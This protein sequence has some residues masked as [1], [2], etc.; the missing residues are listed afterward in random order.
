VKKAVKRWGVRILGWVLLVLGI[1]ALPLPGPGAMIILVAMIV[2]ATQY[3]WAEKRLD[4][5]KEW[6]LVGAADSV[7][8]YPRI[9]L[10]ALGVAWLVGLGIFWGIRPDA[11]DW[12]PIHEKWWLVGGWGTGATLIFSGAVA[13]GLLV[14]SLVK[15][16]GVPRDRVVA[17]AT[18]EADA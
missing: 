10:S 8:T 9:V 5:V 2:L 14:Y 16:R 7:R 3:E 18:G 12:W 4:R 1:A 17:V 6:A 11:P 13:L 15:L